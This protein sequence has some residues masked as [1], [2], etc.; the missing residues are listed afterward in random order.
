MAAKF[1]ATFFVIGLAVSFCGFIFLRVV[2]V[3]IKWSTKEVNESVIKNDLQIGD[4][5]NHIFVFMQISDIHL[6]VVFDPTRGPDLYRFCTEVIDIVNPKVVLATGDLTDARAGM[7]RFAFGSYQVKEEWEMYHGVLTR[8][9]VT[10]KTRWIDIRGNHDNFNV[11]S[12]N[13]P[14]NYYRKYSISGS[15]NHSSHFATVISDVNSVSKTTDMYAFVGVDACL[16]PGPKRPFN[17]IGVLHDEDI[18]AIKALRKTVG[19][20][21]MTFWFGHYPTSA[22]AEPSSG[23]RDVIDGPYFCGH[24][25]INNLYASQKSGF[26]ELELSDW[27]AKRKFRVMAVDHGLFSFTDVVLDQWPIILITNPKSSQFIMPSYEPFHRIQISSHIRALIYSNVTIKVVEARI[28]DSNWIGMKKVG[29]GPLYVAEWN[30]KKFSDG[31]HFI[32]IRASDVNSTREVHHAFSLDGSKEEFRGFSRFALRF[33]IRSFFRYIYSLAIICTV[34]PM[35]I[36]RLIDYKKKGRTLLNPVKG[37]FTKLL[38]KFYVTAC[39]NKIFIPMIGIPLYSTFGPWLVGEIIE[40][41]Y[42]VCFVWGMYIDGSY[43]PGGFTYIT[44]VIFLLFIHT[45]ASICIAWSVHKRYRHLSDG[46]RV[47][48]CESVFSFGNIPMLI[49]L[50]GHLY[51]SHVFVTS[52]GIVAWFAGF[53]FTWTWFIYLTMWILSRRLS[54]KDFSSNCLLTPKQSSTA[55]ILQVNRTVEGNENSQLID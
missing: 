12:W 37:C 9:N 1:L 33:P 39:V 21:N 19:T 35:V 10:K 30:P 17:F 2:D 16:H 14:N 22:I 48:S 13:D 49:I 55:V 24:L 20:P 36:L 29:N 45:P 5:T 27:R 26:M 15:Q 6:S 41:K 38:S 54:P 18:T 40:G 34:L 3:D 53:L 43:L 44:A 46:R 11:E 31:L 52:Y 42:G 25:H 23:I 51:W 28:D 32:T 8:S 50:A 4:D 7:A 47:M